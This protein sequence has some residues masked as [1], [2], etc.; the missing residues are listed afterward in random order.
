MSS[1]STGGLTVTALAL[2]F[3]Y[4]VLATLLF[5]IAL[6]Y[7]LFRTVRYPN[8]M[9]E[10]SG[11]GAKGAGSQHDRPWWVH[12][13]SLGELQGLAGFLEHARIGREQ[14]IVTVLSVSARKQ[15]SARL[16]GYRA[17]HAPLDLWFCLLPFLFRQRPRALILLETEIWPGWITAAA[18][19]RIPVAVVSARISDRNWSKIAR[20]RLLYRPF[21]KT[22]AA[23]SAQSA[24]DAKRWRS[25]GAPHVAVTGNLK[26]RMALDLSSGAVRPTRVDAGPSGRHWIFVAGSL[27]RGEEEVLEAARELLESQ[28][29]V[30][31]A[32][33]H[34]KEVEHWLRACDASRV[35][36]V[37]R[38]EL[39]ESITLLAERGWSGERKGDP[40]SDRSASQSG[41]SARKGSNEAERGVTQISHPARALLID[42]HGELSEWYT[43]ASAAFVGGTLNGRG[44]HSLFEPASAGCPTAFGPSVES[45]RDVADALLE[46]GGGVMVSNARELA[47]WIRSLR[48]DEGRREAQSAAALE[49]ARELATSG[50]RAVRYLRERG[51]AIA[52]G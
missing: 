15:V 52:S 13:A 23:V 12:G 4:Q 25:L 38:S 6:P 36:V 33:R 32:P 2:G 37:L 49:T 46:S 35:P 41:S 45:V 7:L 40:A 18:I 20:W 29:D 16:P 28:V 50:P 27:R 11:W 9:R 47:D 1:G 5:V 21:C 24:V 14:A 10:R 39:D 8:E 17:M 42:R 19:A 43:L 48:A 30:V 31:L 51:F 26:Y 34:P 3:V 44:G 22:I